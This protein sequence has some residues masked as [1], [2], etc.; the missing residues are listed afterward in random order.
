VRAL[1]EHV[2][3]DGPDD[4]RTYAERRNPPQRHPTDAGDRL[5][6]TDA[7]RLGGFDRL[8]AHALAVAEEVVQPY[9]ELLR[10]L[11]DCR[12]APASDIAL[13]RQ[14]RQGATYKTLAA[15]AHAAGMTKAERTGWYRVAE[16]VPLSQR[17]AGHIMAKLKRKAA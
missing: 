11:S 12:E 9:A 8:T 4:R 3:G 5:S 7:D 13:T 17:H 2:T 10:L 16:S 1:Y 15:I 6:F 14:Q